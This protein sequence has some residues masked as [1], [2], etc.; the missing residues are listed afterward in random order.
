MSF[1]YFLRI[2][3]RISYGWCRQL[4]LFL[5]SKIRT[6]GFKLSRLYRVSCSF[7]F[8]RMVHEFLE[9]RLAYY[10]LLSKIERSFPF[11]TFVFELSGYDTFSWHRWCFTNFTSPRKSG[12]FK[13]NSI[14]LMTFSEFSSE[15]VGKEFSRINGK[16]WYWQF[17]TKCSITFFVFYNNNIHFYKLPKIII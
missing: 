12:I 5:S 2:L 14:K 3:T 16:L 9:I 15:V 17:I 13:F 6:L 8:I 4:F 10:Q 1:V 7:L 11:Q